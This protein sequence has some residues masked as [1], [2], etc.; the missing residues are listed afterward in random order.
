M[1][2]DRRPAR[3]GGSYRN[4][5][6]IAYQNLFW[7]YGH[8][9][10]YV[11]FF[12]FVGAVA[13]VVSVHSPAAASSATAG[14][15]SR[16]SSSPRCR[17]RSGPTTCSPPGRT[18][19]STSRS[20][21]S[22]GGSGRH[23]V[24]RSD[25]DPAGGAICFAPRCCSPWVYPPVPDR[26]PDR[27]PARLPP[28]DYPFTT[29]S[30]SSPTSTT[31]CSLAACSAS[32]P[33]SITGFPR[34]PAYMLGERLGK[35]HLILMAIGANVTYIPMFSLGYEVCPAGPRPT[36][37]AQVRDAQPDLQHRRRDHR[38]RDL[39]LHLEHLRLRRAQAQSGLTRGRLPDARMGDVLSAVP[40]NFNA[41][42]PFPK[43][44]SFTPA[45][46]LR[47]RL[48]GKASQ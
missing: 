15:R 40:V 1:G 9:V 22:A 48:S 27:D 23:R 26:R 28:I 29:A 16:C 42:C 20:P 24:L 2:T 3:L 5:G 21:P 17:R 32:S 12:P 39:R 36:R 6:P 11:M 47:M 44:R 25:R 4:G 7:F 8:P 41:H 30:S 10:V 45:L 37:P 43:I 46:D 34:P 31:R 14:S 19:M 38:H 35:L 13:E 18:P 33:G